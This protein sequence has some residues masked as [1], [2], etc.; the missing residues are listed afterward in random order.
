MIRNDSIDD[1]VVNYSES[2][3]NLDKDASRRYK[4]IQVPFNQYEYEVLV[5]LCDR[6]NRSKLNMIRHALISYFEKE[7]L[8][9]K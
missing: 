2:V 5:A 7:S 4:A 9:L 6:T 1:S 3:K 8:S